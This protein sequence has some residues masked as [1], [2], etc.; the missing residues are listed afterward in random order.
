[1]RGSSHIIENAFYSI[2][3]TILCEVKGESMW[4]GKWEN[5]SLQET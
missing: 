1:M 4:T 3:W 5:R 2:T